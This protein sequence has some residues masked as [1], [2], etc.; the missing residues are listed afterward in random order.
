M[1]QAL[2]ATPESIA[3][4]NAWQV[5]V[6][7]FA[8]HGS[9]ET[10]LVLKPLVTRFAHLNCPHAKVHVSYAPGLGSL[11]DPPVTRQDHDQA[12]NT[13]EQALPSRMP[14]TFGTTA[15]GLASK[16]GVACEFW[17]SGLKRE[18]QPDGTLVIRSYND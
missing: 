11:V 6:E 13:L 15:K 2:F 5:T 10:V 12:V 8:R 17:S 14:V 3:A 18:T 9:T 4:S 1:A 7:S 16:P